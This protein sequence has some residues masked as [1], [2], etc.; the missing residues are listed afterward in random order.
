MAYIQTCRQRYIVEHS[1]AF[2]N[3]TTL[4]YEKA[5]VAN[6]EISDYL[7]FACPVELQ[8]RIAFV[9]FNQFGNYFITLIIL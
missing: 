3:H 2:T 1:V 6:Y 5:W 7:R 4:I 9:R 8:S